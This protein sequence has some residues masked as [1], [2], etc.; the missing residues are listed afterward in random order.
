MMTVLP[1]TALTAALALLA[2]AV[3]ALAEDSADGTLTGR[4][5]VLDLGA[6]AMLQPKYPG[7][8]EYIVVP[9]PLIGVSRFYIPGLGQV[10]DGEETIRGI[11]IYPSF[12]FYGERKASDS[13]DL[14][15]TRTVDWALELGLGVAYRYD[16]VRGFV[17]LRQGFNGYSGQVA[18]FGID[19]I[20]EPTERMT[21]VLGPRAT[22]ASSGFMDT[23]FGVSSAEAAASGGNLAAY[24]A[25][26][27]FRSVGLAARVSYGLTDDWTFHVQGGYDR[28]VG[29]A[30]DSPITHL[31]DE[32]QFTLG[33]GFTYRFAFDVFEN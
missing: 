24:N 30:A 23:Y 3:P 12:N 14:D 4:Q 32:N 2:A 31:G 21:L 8:D 15:G 19:F 1:K 29:D 17:E 33:A 25:S 6:G 22:W 18:D 27:G 20:A 26:S 11:S 13:N 10:A 7:A 5:Y 9:Y 28:L 16:W